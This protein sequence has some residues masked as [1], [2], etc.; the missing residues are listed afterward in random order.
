VDIAVKLQLTK[1][2]FAA[3]LSMYICGAISESILGYYVDFVSVSGRDAKRYG[4]KPLQYYEKFV[5]SIII[6]LDKVL[7]PRFSNTERYK[8]IGLQPVVRFGVFYRS[9]FVVLFF[10]LVCMV[11]LNAHIGFLCMH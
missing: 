11:I 6:Y 3:L 2:S 10:Y 4:K 5:Y 1:Y 7:A 8:T 9:M